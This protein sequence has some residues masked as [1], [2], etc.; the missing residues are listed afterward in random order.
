MTWAAADRLGRSSDQVALV[1]AIEGLLATLSLPV[2]TAVVLVRIGDW[3][4]AITLH[5]SQCAHLQ[6]QIMRQVKFVHT[7]QN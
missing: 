3:K 2:N 7:K 6:S 5:A 1:H 4:E